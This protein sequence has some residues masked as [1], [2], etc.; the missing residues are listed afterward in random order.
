MVDIPDEEK[1]KET[2]RC[3]KGKVWYLC[4]IR[5]GPFGASTAADVNKV[6][7]E[8]LSTSDQLQGFQ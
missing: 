8:I 2:Q 7:F 5:H 4:S 6:L 3:L 1:E